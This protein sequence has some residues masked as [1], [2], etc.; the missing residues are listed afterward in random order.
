MLA[1]MA[2]MAMMVLGAGCKGGGV[3][4][5]PI[6]RLSAEESLAQGKELLAKEK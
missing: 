5:D 3:A 2:V 6:L 4:D 1:M